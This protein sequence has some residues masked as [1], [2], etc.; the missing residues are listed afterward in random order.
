VLLEDGVNHPD[1]VVG[2]SEVGQQ[3]YRTHRKSLAQK[4]LRIERVSISDLARTSIV[5]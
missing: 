1:V 2:E 4:A 3:S 5:R